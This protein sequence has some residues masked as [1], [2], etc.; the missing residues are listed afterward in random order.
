ME[1][2]WRA[3]GAHIPGATWLPTT[4]TLEPSSGRLREP[5]ELA[6]LAEQA[7]L[8]ADEP[9]ALYCGGGISAT[10]VLLALR[11]AGYRDLAVYDGSW[12]EWSADPDLPQERHGP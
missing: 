7:G 5:A 10:Q 4:A 12:A 11:A 1:T 2:T 9:L 8:H 6:E 3:A